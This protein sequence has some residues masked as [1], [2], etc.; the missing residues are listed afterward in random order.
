VY[1]AKELDSEAVIQLCV[2]LV[3]GIV[4]GKGLLAQGLIFGGAG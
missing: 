1:D 3:A 4:K 2:S